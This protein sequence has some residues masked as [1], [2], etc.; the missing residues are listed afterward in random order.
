MERIDDRH[1][2]WNF[3]GAGEYSDQKFLM[4]TP[5]VITAI[6]VLYLWFV[7]KFGPELMKKRPPFKLEKVLLVYNAV[8]VMISCYIFQ[9]GFRFLINNGMWNTRCLSETEEFRKQVVDGSHYYFLAK[10]V[11]LLD[12]VFFVL[13]KKQ[14]QVTFLHV[15]HHA[16]MASLVWAIVKYNRTDITVFLGV[17]NSLVHVVMYG[18]YGLSVFPS[19]TKYLWWKKYITMMQLIQFSLMFIHTIVTHMV[20]ECRPSEALLITVCFNTV[21]FMYLFGDFYVKSYIKKYNRKDIVNAGKVISN[22][23][24]VT[25]YHKLAMKIH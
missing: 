3:K 12:T 24:N 22:S 18:Y 4:S 1:V 14:K 23:T 9:L 5:F 21:L 20:S 11:E 8:Q 15:Y 7:I 17:I 10:V 6:V 19:L 25:N 2:F 16:M 13:R